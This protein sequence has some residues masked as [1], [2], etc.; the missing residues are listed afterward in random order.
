MEPENKNER[1]NYLSGALSGV[2]FIGLLVGIV[3][4]VLYF[5]NKSNTEIKLPKNM[6][7]QNEDANQNNNQKVA[8]SAAA[9]TQPAEPVKNDELQYAILKQ[10]SGPE[11]KKGDKVSVHYVGT[12]TD[13][14]KFDSSVDRGTPFSFTLGAGQVIQGWDVGVAGMKIGERRR[15]VIPP[16]FGYGEEGTPGGPIPPN[17]TLIFEVELLKIN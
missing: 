12:L 14:T 4:S 6:A 8:P 16:K 9:N 7:G 15:L 13:G 11:A 2:I 3:Y 10:G 17:A 5:A 1:M